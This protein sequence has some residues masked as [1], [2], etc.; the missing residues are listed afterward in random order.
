MVGVSVGR[1]VVCMCMC[2]C[3]CVYINFSFC[4]ALFVVLQNVWVLF[5][6]VEWSVPLV[7]KT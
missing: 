2:V 4:K 5:R 6:W 3:V 7:C 1:G